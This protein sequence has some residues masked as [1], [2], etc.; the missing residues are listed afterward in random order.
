MR[1]SESEKIPK[2]KGKKDSNDHP[3]N[4]WKRTVFGEKSEDENS[5]ENA[6]MCFS[7]SKRLEKTSKEKSSVGPYEESVLLTEELNDISN[8][9]HDS[10]KDSNFLSRTKGED[11]IT[12]HGSWDERNPGDQAKLSVDEERSLIPHSPG[13]LKCE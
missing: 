8:T 1:S 9:G 5:A 2:C 10:R 13:K 6:N 7:N 11:K 12:S 4:L 3:Y